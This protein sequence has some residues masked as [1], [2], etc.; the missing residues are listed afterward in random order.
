M[1]SNPLG[2]TLSRKSFLRGAVAGRR[3][4][5]VWTVVAR[6]AP[7]HWTIAG[8]V[9]GGGQGVITYRC[10]PGGEGTLF[11]R[12]FTYAMLTRWL[13]VLDRLVFRRRV[14]R[15][16]AQAVRQLRQAIEAQAPE[17]APTTMGQ[18]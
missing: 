12:E 6:D 9:I 4:V 11:E 16:S 7:T 17:A 13:T 18:R 1:S 3:G 5:V 8:Q 15:E 2:R 10:T 14:A